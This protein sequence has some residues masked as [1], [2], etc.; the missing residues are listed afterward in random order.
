MVFASL[1]LEQTQNKGQQR[2]KSDNKKT[3]NSYAF[4][5][6]TNTQWSWLGMFR[7]RHFSDRKNGL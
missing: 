6:L 5:S 2:E 4:T 1:I 3:K 7:G